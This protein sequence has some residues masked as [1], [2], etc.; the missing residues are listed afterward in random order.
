[1]VKKN[2]KKNRKP[3]VEINNNN[4]KNSFSPTQLVA[5]NEYRIVLFRRCSLDF[6]ELGEFN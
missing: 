5:G 3:M 1:V 2:D 4:K 6:A